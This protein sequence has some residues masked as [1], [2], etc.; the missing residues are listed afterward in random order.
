MQFCAYYDSAWKLEERDRPDCKRN[1]DKGRSQIPSE[2]GPSPLLF[3]GG[4]V[5][6]W[7]AGLV[8]ER[9]WICW[10]RLEQNEQVEGP[11]S[12]WD[13]D[14]I[15]QEPAQQAETEIQLN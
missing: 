9:R 8:L 7:T 13:A 15:L 11:H 2:P 6:G 10:Q 5:A 4:H 1:R 3:S 12:S 14:S